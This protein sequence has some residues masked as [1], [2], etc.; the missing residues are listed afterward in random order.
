[1]DGA[2]ECHSGLADGFRAD[3]ARS[4]AGVASAGTGGEDRRSQADS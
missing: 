1:M 2:D 4:K 3:L